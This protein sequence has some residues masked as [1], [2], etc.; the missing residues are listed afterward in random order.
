MRMNIHKNSVTD[1]SP[2]FIT[3]ELPAQLTESS[4]ITRIDGDGM[5]GDQLLFIGDKKLAIFCISDAT[6][7]FNSGNFEKNIE[8]LSP[9]LKDSL[10]VNDMEGAAWDAPKRMA[11]V[12]VSGSKNS[13]DKA[14]PER[15]KLIRLRFDE[16]TGE[17]SGQEVADF[18]NRSARAALRARSTWKVSLCSPMG[19]CCLVFVRQPIPEM[20][21]IPPSRAMLWL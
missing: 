6:T 17:W 15:E 8:D 1:V 7:C 3:G 16:V 4:G 2:Q 21:T 12:L 11:F 10:D 9:Q 14:K 20:Q 13:K 19:V 5:Q 18:K